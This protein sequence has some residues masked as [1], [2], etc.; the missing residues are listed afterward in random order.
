LKFGNRTLDATFA[1]NVTAASF[2]GNASTATAFKT[3]QTITV[4]G[5]ATGSVEFN[6]TEAKTLTLDV[7]SAAKTDYALTVNVTNVAGTTTTTTFNGSGAKTVNINA[8]D[9]MPITEF[10]SSMKLTTSW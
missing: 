10:T 6:G 7:A 1:G 5:D 8:S 2:I 9:F 4:A 3:A